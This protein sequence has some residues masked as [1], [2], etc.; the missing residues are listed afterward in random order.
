MR[1]TRTLGRNIRSAD[2]A[3]LD[4]G[5]GPD[6]RIWS[7]H[8]AAGAI[9]VGRLVAL[10][11]ASE[12]AT[13]LPGMQAVVAAASAGAGSLVYGAPLG[14]N[15]GT[16][17]TGKLNANETTPLTY[18]ASTTTVVPGRAAV[19]GDTIEVLRCGPGLIFW[20]D[21]TTNGTGST[22]IGDVLGVATNS[23]ALAD[24]QV[25]RLA[26]QG[27]GSFL[28]RITTLEASTVT[29]TTGTGNAMKVMVHM[30]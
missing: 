5:G 10:T 28:A 9:G 11:T 21:A 13:T 25:Q 7:Y 20:G 23:T 29:A 14:I 16:M 6:G 2:S 12:A 19:T 24:G 18:A 17:G 1:F 26:T 8:R 15:E 3:P 27:A 22:V 30:L 4:I